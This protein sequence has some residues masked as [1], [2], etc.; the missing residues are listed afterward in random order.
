MKKD[1]FISKKEKTFRECTLDFLEDTFGLDQI[2][3]LASLT[4]WLNEEGTISGHEEVQLKLLQELLEF[5]VHDWNEQELDMN[6]IGPVFSLVNFSSKKY[7]LFA[8]R[9]IEA[10]VGDWRLFGAPDN[11]IASGRRKPKIPYFAFQEYKKHKDPKG[12]PAAQ[13]L[14]AALVAQTLNK[15]QTPIYGCYVI[16]HDWYF[17]ILEDK[18]FA[19]SRDY[20]A[21]SDEI[22]DIFR[23]LRALKQ[24]VIGFTSDN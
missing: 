1:T 9:S 24:I 5:N 14:A 20:S 16:G 3:N 15:N 21:L 2:K 8:E 12:D 23:I 6:F 13:A 19:V 17:F 7:N 18:Q 22:F 11:M 4:K 10:E